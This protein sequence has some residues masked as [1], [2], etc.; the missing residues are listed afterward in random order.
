[1]TLYFSNK[2]RIIKKIHEVIS[3]FIWI[4][5]TKKIRGN[6]ILKINFTFLESSHGAN[7]VW[8]FI[9]LPVFYSD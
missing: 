9:F 4:L 6:C 5:D 3:V 2:I 1:M 8:G 7:E